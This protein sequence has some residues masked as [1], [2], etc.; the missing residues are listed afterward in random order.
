MRKT[1][2]ELPASTDETLMFRYLSFSAWS[3]NMRVI[4]SAIVSIPAFLAYGN[5]CSMH[6]SIK[7]FRQTFFGYP[8]VDMFYIGSNAVKIHI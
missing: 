8:V 3:I 1:Q 2:F 4:M 6:I 5:T 7:P